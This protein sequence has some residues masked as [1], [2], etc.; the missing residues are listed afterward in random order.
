MIELQANDEVKLIAERRMA[1]GQNLVKTGIN[2][3]D[4]CTGGIWP[5]DFIVISA[6]SGAGKSEIAS[7]IAQNVSAKGKRVLFFALE[8]YHGEVTDRMVYRELGKIVYEKYKAYI[9]YKDYLRGLYDAEYIP[10]MKQAERTAEKKRELMSVFYREGET[11]IEDLVKT[12]E[13]YYSPEQ[14]KNIAD[15]I[16]IDHLAY[17]DFS[18]EKEYTAIKKAVRRIRDLTLK[19]KVPVILVAH[20]RKSNRML[21]EIVPDMEEIQG[22]SEIFKEATQVITIAPY[23][24]ANQEHRYATLFR[25]G[26]FRLLGSVKRYVGAHYFNSIT[27]E[28]EPDYNVGITSFD[29]KEL[30]LLS[31]QDYPYWAKFKAGAGIKETK[32][33]EKQYRDYTDTSLPL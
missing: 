15:L 27:N 8:S 30:K 9:N 13:E 21:K 31:P 16:I 22:A 33:E 14:F 4:D 26:K 7:I 24:Q 10:E 3:L 19:E 23:Y 6:K 20:L 25:V 1:N 18:D 11:K 5:G 29:E 12:V 2:Y 32:K 28:Y 17:F